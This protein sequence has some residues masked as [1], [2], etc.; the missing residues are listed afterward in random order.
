MAVHVLSSSL[1]FFFSPLAS[2]ALLSFNIFTSHSVRLVATIIPSSLYTY[3]H[4]GPEPLHFARPS[5]HGISREKERENV[6]T[7]H[8]T[9][10]YLASVQCAIR[11]TLHRT[12]YSLLFSS[13]THIGSPGNADRGRRPSGETAPLAYCILHA[14]AA[15]QSGFVVILR[16]H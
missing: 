13:L 8:L 3:T 10:F 6:F 12:Q 11:C 14:N 15:C 4:R 9:M 5:V 2:R 1:L 7:L 16:L